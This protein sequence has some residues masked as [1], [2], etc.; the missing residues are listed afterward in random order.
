MTG[1]RETKIGPHPRCTVASHV[2]AAGFSSLACHGYWFARLAI[3]ASTV[4]FL[5]GR[6]YFA[7]GQWALLYLLVILLVASVAGAWPGVVSAVLAFLAWDFFFLPPY[8]TFVI[9]DLRDWLASSP[10]SSSA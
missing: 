8:G 3:A 5:P 2:P 7:K 1:E 10:F 4:V 6:A 9:A